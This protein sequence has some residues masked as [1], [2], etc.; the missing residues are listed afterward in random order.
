M[1]VAYTY[2][3]RTGDII[4]MSWP[5]AY[6]CARTVLSLTHHII[7]RPRPLPRAFCSSPAA[8]YFGQG[9][10]T[11]LHCAFIDHRDCLTKTFE[12]GFMSF[13]R[14]ITI[15]SYLELSVFGVSLPSGSLP[16]PPSKRF[17]HLNKV[18]EQRVKEGMKKKS[19][20]PPGHAEI[21]RYFD[22][23]ETRAESADPLS[24]WEEKVN[25]YLLLSSIGLDVLAVP[26]S[27]AP[28]ERVFSTAG[29]STIR[30][31]NRLTDKNLERSFIEKEQA[32]SL[33]TS[34]VSHLL[35]S[36]SIRQQTEQS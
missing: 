10:S 30:K 31:R 14:R 26:A 8:I 22:S 33:S 12:R 19:V 28:I 34:S 18:L 20:N 16:E 32:F 5:A 3:I 36:A 24:Y 29:D 2:N 15:S 7:A 11:L 35:S 21:E 13:L 9:R 23:V 1:Y 25:D 6:A 17:R 4:I 27:S